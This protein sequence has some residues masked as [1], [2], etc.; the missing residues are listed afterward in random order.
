MNA[1]IELEA[2]DGL[3]LPSLPLGKTTEGLV[4]RD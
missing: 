4:V 2:I 1:R 3:G